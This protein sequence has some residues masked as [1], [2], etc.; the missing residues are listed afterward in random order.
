MKE[1]AL[2]L[3]RGALKTEV[4][5]WTLTATLTV[6]KD[7]SR[8]QFECSSTTIAQDYPPRMWKTVH[9]LPHVYLFA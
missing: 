9:P 4:Q 7:V 6:I 8:F 5:P 2:A 1:D 3:H